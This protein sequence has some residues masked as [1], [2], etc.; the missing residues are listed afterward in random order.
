MPLQ[1]VDGEAIGGCA[2]AKEGLE[3]CKSEGVLCLCK[4]GALCL[5]KGGSK[6][7]WREAW[8][9]PTVLTRLTSLVGTTGT[10]EA[11]SVSLDPHR[12]QQC[13]QAGPQKSEWEDV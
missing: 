4:G 9:V 2:F 10:C 11:V 1:K 12:G 5:C 8:T 6:G 3:R 13:P 7:G